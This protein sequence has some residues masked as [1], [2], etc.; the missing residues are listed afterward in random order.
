MAKHGHRREPARVL[1]E[2]GAIAEA[3]CGAKHVSACVALKVW[4]RDAQHATGHQNPVR[5]SHDGTAAIVW[6]QVLN[7]VFRVHHLDRLRAEGQ[8]SAAVKTQ[9][10]IVCPFV[11]G[12]HPTLLEAL[13]AEC[14]IYVKPPFMASVP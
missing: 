1:P 4:G 14:H 9:D 6:Q 8:L 13:V 10:H 3:E 5:L 7:H 12:G 11:V 2:E